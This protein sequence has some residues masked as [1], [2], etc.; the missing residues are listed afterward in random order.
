MPHRPDGSSRSASPLHH[1]LKL[2]ICGVALGLL[3]IA[4]SLGLEGPEI[5]SVRLSLTFSVLGAVYA[6][7]RALPSLWSALLGGFMTGLGYFGTSVYWLGASA[8]PNPD[9]FVFGEIILG[10]GALWLFVPW[11]SVWFGLAYLASR[12]SQTPSVDPVSFVLSFSIANLM[13][14]DLVMGIPLVPLSLIAIDTSLAPMLGLVGQFGLDSLVVAAGA[15]VG[16]LLSNRRWQPALALVAV[17]VAVLGAWGSVPAQR[18]PDAD[19]ATGG[20]VYVA[21]PSLPHVALMDPANVLTIVHGEALRQIREGVDAGAEL[22][23]LP[24]GALRVDLTSPDDTLTAE[25]SALLPDGVYVLAGFGRVVVDQTEQGFTVQPFNSVALIDRNGVRQVHDKAHLVPF[26]ETMPDIF[27]KM[28][29][30]VVAGPAGGLGSG[31]R[32]SVLDDVGDIPGFALVICY[33]A[34][35]SGA[36]SRESEGALWLLNISAETLFRGTIGPRLLHDHIRLRA[37][38][39][40][41]PILRSTAHAFSGGIDA[42]G[43]SFGLLAPEARSGITLTIPEPQ[44]TY[45]RAVGYRDYYVALS[46]LTILVL[47]AGLFGARRRY[48]RAAAPFSASRRA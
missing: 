4:A 26:G 29:F 9:T 2:V 11:W 27:F 5:A 22:I 24:E 32:L 43:V 36:V 41:L 39:T 8:N 35:L 46:G 47:G 40:G 37:I 17:C 28:G 30:N 3:Q 13:L 38:E 25:I 18:L 44:P 42:D 12:L 20:T 1:Y 16:V 15:A 33:E 31:D 21:Q 19:R 7:W 10:A 6:L 45:F 34:I 14:A 48:H 23:V